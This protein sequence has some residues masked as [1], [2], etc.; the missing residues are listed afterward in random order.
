M[1]SNNFDWDSNFA[2]LTPPFGKPR[3]PVT[4]IS[5]YVYDS[6]SLGKLLLAADR[7]R[8]LVASTYVHGEGDEDK[9]LAKI[10]KQMSPRILRQRGMF[11]QAITE[12]EEY[13]RGE[14]Q[15]FDVT[16]DLSLATPFQREV[17][18][19]VRHSLAYG[20]VSTYSDVARHIQRPQARRAVG[21]ALGANPVCVF[22]PCHRVLGAGGQLSGYAGGPTTKRRL[23]ELE[24]VG[25]S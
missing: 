14:R 24:G 23:L 5:Y 8:T 19:E 12:L 21:T 1:E 2:S 6:P 10:S 18:D 16:V 22:V 15:I 25:I 11:D 20:Q 17:L 3:L 9:L 13:L 4:D 7:Q